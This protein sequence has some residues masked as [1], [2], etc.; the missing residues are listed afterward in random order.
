[1]LL[2]TGNPVVD[3]LAAHAKQ[4][5]NLAYRRAAIRLQHRQQTPVQSRIARL[6]QHDLYLPPL[7]CRQFH[8]V[9]GVF[10]VLR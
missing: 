9:H 1:L 5:G 3:T 7:A 10:L 8:F 2:E 4:L 6:A